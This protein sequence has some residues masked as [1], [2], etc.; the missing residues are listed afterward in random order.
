MGFK[1]ESVM[2]ARMLYPKYA[3]KHALKGRGFAVLTC[4]LLLSLASIIFT[5]SMALSQ[6]LNNQIVGN[7]YRAN[8]AFINAESGVN[9]V[10]SQLDETSTAQQMLAELPMQYIDTGD[11]YSVLITKLHNNKL[12]ITSVGQALDGHAKREINLQIDFYLN[13]PIPNTPVSIN[14]KLNLG[15][16]SLINDGCEGLAVSDCL[17]PGNIAN[18]ILVSNPGI[19]ESI[20]GDLCSAAKVDENNIASGVLQGHSQQKT[21]SKIIDTDKGIDYDWG[22]VLIPEGSKVAGIAVDSNLEAG[23]LFEATFGIEMIQSNLDELWHHAAQIDMTAG[24]DCSQML[25]QVSDDNELIY[26]KGDCDIS[27]YYALQSKSSTKK[28]FTIGSID[29]PK[30]ILMQGG[31][32]KSSANIDTNVVGLLYFL[33]SKRDLVDNNGNLIN[34]DGNP[35]L[36]TEEAIRVEDASIDMGGVNVNG[37]LL[38]EYKCSHDGSGKTDDNYASRPLLARFDKHILNALYAKVGIAATSSG[39]R[40]SPGTWRDF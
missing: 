27:D 29:N 24:G 12:M 21:I 36:A 30:L 39:Y 20:I 26:I 14:G 6:L 11:R 38:S 25:S 7:Y 2:L 3:N 28:A 13:Y 10:L 5:T 34:F 18:N 35:L 4:A 31:T 9:F 8:E 19:E 15:K 32:F 17:T 23:S 22:K 33:P 40:I 1:W 16:G 37:A